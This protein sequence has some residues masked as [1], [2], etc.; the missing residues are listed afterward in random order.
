[1]NI[2]PVSWWGSHLELMFVTLKKRGDIRIE[3]KAEENPEGLFGHVF[4]CVIEILPYLHAHSIFP[5]WRIR[6]TH[7]GGSDG[8]V[9]PGALELA[10]EVEPGPKRE[11]NLARLRSRHRHLLGSDWQGVSALWH[12]YFRIPDRIS[13]RAKAL[14]TLSDAIGIHYRGNDKQTAL[15]DTNPVSHEDYLAIIRQFCQERPEFQRIFLATDD[16]NFYRFLKANISLEVI[17]LGDVGFHKDEALPEVAAAKTDR[18]V[19]DCVLLS[20]CGVVLLTSSALPSFAKIIEPT[21]EIYRV[22]AS[23]IFA[24]APYFPVAYIP[25]YNSSSPEVAALVGQLMVG[26]WSK[27][28][29]A[30]LFTAPFVSRSHYSPT[31]RLIYSYVRRLAPGWIARLPNWLAGYRR[32]WRLRAQQR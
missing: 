18:A 9:I 17:N 31:A 23:K 20:R 25:T 14:G 4:L 1:M 3:S 19:L 21:L 29:Y 2:T 32:K 10:Y 16:F 8:L 27:L 6:A 11:L 7:Y 13:D 28:A 22:A 12:T 30:E 5:D 24:S 15:W 26:D